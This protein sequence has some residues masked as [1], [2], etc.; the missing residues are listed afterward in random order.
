MYS[1]NGKFN[2]VLENEVEESLHEVKHKQKKEWEIRRR[3]GQ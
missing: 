3:V 2:E 1:R